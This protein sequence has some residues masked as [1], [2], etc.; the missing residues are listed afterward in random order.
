MTVRGY[1]YRATAMAVRKRI[2]SGGFDLVW[3]L[4]NVAG[5]KWLGTAYM[6]LDDDES[7]DPARDKNA[8]SERQHVG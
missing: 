4:R 3:E 6:D 7:E 2:T 8:S 1:I 5:T